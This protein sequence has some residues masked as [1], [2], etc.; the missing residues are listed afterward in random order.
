MSGRLITKFNSWVTKSIYYPGD[1]EE[2][3]LLKRI[4]WTAILFLLLFLSLF[5]P[6]FYL[7]RITNWVIAD[8][9]YVGFH[10]INL[11]IFYKVRHGIKWFALITQIWYMIFSF[12]LV[13]IGGGILHSGG[14]VL[15]GMVG[16]L[17]A[18]IFQNKRLAVIFLISYLFTI[19]IEAVLQP[20]LLPYPAITPGINLV[21]FL[22][23]FFTI[24]SVFFITLMYYASQTNKMK[25]TETLRL[26]ELDDAKT[27]LYTNISH[28]F[29]TPLTIILGIA[30][31]M[32]ENSVISPNEGLQMI[33]R[34]GENL[35]RLINQLLDLS[36]IEA[37]AMPVNYFQ[38][39]IIAY[40]RYIFQSFRSMAESKNIRLKFHS[41]IDQLNMDFD[42]GKILQ[43]IS[44]LLSNAIKYTPEGGDIRLIIE[45]QQKNS[46]HELIVKVR[47]NGI[48]IPPDKLPY[49]FDRFYKVD[50]NSFTT[51]KGTGIGLALAKE[52]VFLLKGTVNVQSIPEDGTEFIVTLPVTNHSEMKLD[53]GFDRFKSDISLFTDTNNKAPVKKVENKRIKKNL[54]KLIIVEDNPDVARY[55]ESI[56]RL[57]Y[58]VQIATNG[59]EGLDQATEIIP[60]IVICDVMMPVMNGF[61]LCEKLKTDERTSHIPVILLTAMASDAD[62]LEGL[63]TGA[64]A[65]L[66]KPFN[67]KELQIRIGKLIEQR[68]K[69]RE[70]FS[71]DITLSPREIA[72]TSADERFLIHALEVIENHMGDPEFGVDVFGNEVGMSHSQLHR[73]IQALTNQSPVELIRSIRLKRAATLL[74]QKYGNISEVAYLT[75]FNTPS[76]FSECFQKQFGISPSEY[77]SKG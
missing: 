18:S 51:L 49:I 32:A 5:M 70:R 46:V 59:Q 38:G 47:D 56:L 53:M 23:H 7:F 13:L 54:P 33:K 62:R 77:I 68:R 41:D 9:I 3:I 17:F 67:T 21:F 14:A 4:Y 43:I 36:K 45:K 65:Y 6:I 44:N 15:I 63:E 26:K 28:E 25:Q 61:I 66:V 8:I 34:N 42:P 31:Q 10:I 75:G 1:N 24:V 58:A 64:D 2:T 30:D 48:G 69:L 57:D 29:R 55:I 52:L 39:E 71:R 72:V 16:P 74:K 22:I 73:K 35:L 40:L 50:D 60:D 20:Y 27:K 19:I 11:V 37:K 12:V 76:Y